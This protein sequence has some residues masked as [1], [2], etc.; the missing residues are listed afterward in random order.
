MLL[1]SRDNAL[2]ENSVT[3]FLVATYSPDRLTNCPGGDLRLV[4]TGRVTYS[5]H[6]EHVV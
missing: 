4:E 5:V 3:G 1:E 2:G 6:P